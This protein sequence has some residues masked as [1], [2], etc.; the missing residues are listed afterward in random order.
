M[1]RVRF[2]V[3]V[4]AA[5]AA[6]MLLSVAQS[7]PLANRGKT[8]IPVEP[9]A[10]TKLLMEALAGA[11]MRGLAK[12]LSE[13][14]TEAEA[15]G[16]ARGQALLIAET[17]NLLLMR[18]PKTT[19]GQETWQTQSVGLREAGVALGRAAAAKDYSKSRTA[20]AEVA[21]VCNRCH[22]AFQVPARIDP[23]GE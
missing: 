16:F 2:G 15:W 11:N 17:G 4:A 8:T 9:A 21:N 20:L 22:Q 23:F 6:C 18:P 19:A 12:T 10:D 3:A 13:K 5:G 7:R 14:P 1:S